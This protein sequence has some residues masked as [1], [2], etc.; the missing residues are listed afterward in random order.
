MVG[1]LD[2]LMELLMVIVVKRDEAEW[3]EHHVG[4]STHRFE[5]FGHALYVTGLRLECN[6]NEV[7]LGERLGDLQEA[8][9]CRDRL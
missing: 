4:S 8:P 5:H 6:L 3:L 2:Q 1:R 9:S 7:A